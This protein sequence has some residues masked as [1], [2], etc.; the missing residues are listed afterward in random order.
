MLK[1]LLEVQN[2][3]DYMQ[4]LENYIE[5]AS[6][7]MA[8]LID[9]LAKKGEKGLNAVDL[10]EMQNIIDNYSNIIELTND[11]RRE[12]KRLGKTSTEI[13]SIGN[14]M[15]KRLEELENSYKTL[16]E[17]HYKVALRLAVKMLVAN[18]NGMMVALRDEVRKAYLGTEEGKQ[19]EKEKIG[20]YHKRVQQAVEDII[21]DKNLYDEK[22][23]ALFFENIFRTG[24][25][26]SWV[27]R[28][29]LQGGNTSST[30]LRSLNAMILKSEN[31]SRNMYN[32]K[33]AE[34]DP[35]F[36]EYKKYMKNK[37]KSKN[38]VL[39]L[40][41]NINELDENG[42]ATGYYVGKT[43]SLWTRQK[44]TISKYIQDYANELQRLESENLSETPKFWDEE[45]GEAV[46]ENDKK[47][48]IA[49][50][51]AEKGELNKR[52]NTEEDLKDRYDKLVSISKEQSANRKKFRTVLTEYRALKNK[53]SATAHKK[54]VELEELRKIG[55]RLTDSYTGFKNEYEFELFKRH[56]DV[57]SLPNLKSLTGIAKI[58]KDNLQEGKNVS[59]IEGKNVLKLVIP[60]EVSAYLSPQ[61]NNLDKIAKN[62]PDN[63]EWRYYKAVMNTVAV[64]ERQYSEMYRTYFKKP[65]VNK[66]GAE[67]W[68]SDV[69]SFL[70]F[71]Q[72]I[73]NYVRPVTK[74]KF[75][76]TAGVDYDLNYENTLAIELQNNG[77]KVSQATK[78]L[79][80]YLKETG[81]D[82]KNQSSNI[83]HVVLAGYNN[84]I[85]YKE[86]FNV[87]PMVE[88]F[89]FLLEN[90]ETTKKSATSKLMNAI[91]KAAGKAF[92]DT[93]AY[94]ERVT[95]EKGMA[96]NSR[97]YNN[98]VDM[99]N[100]RLFGQ[101]VNSTLNINL[102][103]TI[104]GRPDLAINFRKLWKLFASYV[105]TTVLSLN[106]KSGA[107]NVIYGEFQYMQEVLGN[108]FVGGKSWAQSQLDYMLDFRGIVN[109]IG[110]DYPTSKM[111]LLGLIFDPLNEY[112]PLE[113]DYRHTN[114]AYAVFNMDSLHGINNIGEHIMQLGTMGGVLRETK[115]VDK[116][117]NY[118]TQK[119]T[120]TDRSK[121]M[122]FFE[123]FEKTSMNEDSYELVTDKRVAGVEIKKGT[124]MERMDF[125]GGNLY[126]FN[127]SK[128]DFKTNRLV[129]DTLTNLIQSLNEEMHG[130]YSWR[131]APPMKRTFLG[132]LLLQMRQ[133]FPT[134]MAARWAGTSNEI[135]DLFLA[136]ATGKGHEHFQ[137]LRDSTVGSKYFDKK[138][139]GD[140]TNM[141]PSQKFDDKRGTL[142]GG[143]NASFLRQ[144]Q[145]FTYHVVL[146]FKKLFNWSIQDA[147]F[148]KEGFLK[149]T[150]EQW[151]KME[152]REKANVK[153]VAIA[154]GARTLLG[155]F[156]AM[157][158]AGDDDDE[159]YYKLAFYTT[160]LHT[161]LSA[162]S[163]KDELFRLLQSP[164]VTLSM[165]NRIILLMMQLQEDAVTGEYEV[166]QSG[167]KKGRTKIGKALRDVLP[168]GKVLEQHKYIEDI[169]NYHYKG[170]IGLVKK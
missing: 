2:D 153:K 62:D 156:A 169:L 33:M 99:V 165:Y 5:N 122:S 3:Q 119:G 28:W 84:A 98:A 151:R 91:S 46:Q 48:L 13:T 109:D 127:L 57:V 41:E 1:Q 9:K 170:Q 59:G 11:A 82:P 104:F 117:G 6:K 141:G 50:K 22:E 81:M 49:L 80:V 32:S 146:A 97:I 54:S 27:A 101:S 149:M 163:D 137:N 51:K 17:S 61:F 53:K 15:L 145:V 96:K 71:G 4:G 88:I 144:F 160:R 132:G 159:R 167:S 18:N 161:E 138:T 106:I 129:L 107:A 100:T 35:L 47:R 24:D 77:Y 108:E 136:L 66:T 113:S 23:T 10:Q 43:S 16:K 56:H 29:A 68:E 79:P 63:I 118:L 152:D 78:Q 73:K 140:F 12:V 135:Q 52:Y 121:A 111:N 7:Q 105:S 45:L 93:E 95:E 69:D 25:D 115:V 110:K 36:K 74:E 124:R 134:G 166:Y 19:L 168:W 147:Q 125:V 64:S 55:Y 20:D 30:L 123:S 89:L 143:R 75:L 85:A 130:P 72:V 76:V 126:D 102:P 164:A 150:A 158:L 87:L 26:I 114:K 14:V 120:T 92:L 90:R 39:E 83:Q 8:S 116:N 40:Y 86:K 67:R 70:N 58:D 142:T 31:T 60:A 42:E 128:R 154:T 44:A 65:E 155:G 112:N 37:G 148:Q 38:S 133:W 94:M 131:T 103:L 157:L 162:Y 21:I 139:W 34:L